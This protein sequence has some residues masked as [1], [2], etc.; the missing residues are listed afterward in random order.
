M[1]PQILDRKLIKEYFFQY[2][3]VISWGAVDSVIRGGQ[4]L[5]LNFGSSYGPE[6]PY[7]GRD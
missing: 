1:P 6:R 7:F 5:S 3:A 2:N 4:M